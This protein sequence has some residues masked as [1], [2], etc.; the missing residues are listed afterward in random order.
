MAG[1]SHV[2]SSSPAAPKKRMVDLQITGGDAA[3]E[4]KID[5]HS[6]NY[7]KQLIKLS[8]KGK[9]EVSDKARKLQFFI[10]K[11][12][13]EGFLDSSYR[14]TDANNQVESA[15]VTTTGAPGTSMR[16]SDTDLLAVFDT[17]G[18]LV[19]SALLRRPMWIHHPRIWSE[20]AANKVYA[21]W[22]GAPVSIYHNRNRH[23]DIH[24]YG[25]WM[26][27]KR[28]YYTSGHYQ[29]DLHKQEAT[30]GCIFIV[31][32]N[33]PDYVPGNTAAIAALN[34]FE[35]Q[36]I[37]DVQQAIGAQVKKNIGIMHMVEIQ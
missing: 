24:Y 37:K 28:G 36:F 19:S 12:G 27:D 9:I 35:P 18:T 30:N 23:W 25:L 13:A 7:L 33:T 21:A 26:N 11:G 22:D 10:I 1:A 29:V 34:S 32:D 5:M 17:D 6:E 15:G 14:N 8:S 31:D 3:K 16:F 20:N 2:Y 4:D